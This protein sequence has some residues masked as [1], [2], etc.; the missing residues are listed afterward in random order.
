MTDAS[1]HSVQHS[2]DLNEPEPDFIKWLKE[3]CVPIVGIVF[4]ALVVCLVAH[5]SSTTVDWARTKDFAEAFASVSQSLALM[6]GGVWAYFKF[7]KG[8]TFRDRL[9]TTV[10]GKLVSMDGSV[11]LIVTIRLQNVG[12]SRIAFDQQVSSL[13]VFEY[14]PPQAEEILSVKNNQLS[15]FRVFGNKDRY[16]EPNEMIERQTL[17]ALPHV[18]KIGYQLELEVLSNSGYEWRTTTVVG[19]SAFEHNEVGKPN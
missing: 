5:Y 8:R 7:A 15:S 19:K 4:G 16:I 9:T 6:A 1:S 11:F 2:A 10:S 17:I 14:V 3:N 18:S 12:L 13:D